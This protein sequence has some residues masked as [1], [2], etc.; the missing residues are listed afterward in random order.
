[1]LTQVR[2][3]SQITIPGAIVKRLGIREGDQL[4]VTEKDGI[5]QLV[6]VAVYPKSYIE[7]MEAEIAQLKGSAKADKQNTANESISVSN[8]IGAAKDLYKGSISLEDFDRDNNIIAEL[9]TEGGL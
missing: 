4:E 6:P 7:Q 2:S 9:L 1:M 5:I 3:K 8:R